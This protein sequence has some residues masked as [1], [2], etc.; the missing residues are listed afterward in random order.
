[1]AYNIETNGNGIYSAGGINHVL[2]EVDHPEGSAMESLNGTYLASVFDS[3][4]PE[5]VLRVDS[6]YDWNNGGNKQIGFQMNQPRL[7]RSVALTL[8][9]NLTFGL[10]S[11]SDQF[12]L[13]SEIERHFAIKI[14]DKKQRK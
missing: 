8:C 9:D 13:E 14:K 11:R 12:T 6:R 7:L 5:S 3:Y 4:F 1:M 2:V 10:K